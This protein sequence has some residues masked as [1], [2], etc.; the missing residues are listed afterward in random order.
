M[1]SIST[2][3]ALVATLPPIQCEIGEKATGEDG[4]KMSILLSDKLGGMGRGI[5]IA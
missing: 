1:L 4:G 3:F 5:S 2:R